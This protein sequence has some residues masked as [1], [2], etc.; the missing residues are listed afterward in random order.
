MA[1][2][3]RIDGIKITEYEYQAAR[4]RDPAQTQQRI[5]QMVA[6]SVWSQTACRVGGGNQFADQAQHTALPPQWP[7]FMMSAIKQ[8]RTDTVTVA[9]RC[10]AN[11]GRGAC[12]NN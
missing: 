3:I 11:Q 8:Q 1:S 5:V 9:H 4:S 10:P 7:Q 6:V 2:R 12:N